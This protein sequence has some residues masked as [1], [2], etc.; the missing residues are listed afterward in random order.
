MNTVAICLYGNS[1]T[2]YDSVVKK[3]ETKFSTFTKSYFCVIDNDP[4]KALW[5]SSFKKAETEILNNTEFDICIAIDLNKPMLLNFI[6]IPD[7]IDNSVYYVRGWFNN[8]RHFSGVDFGSFF[9]KSQTFNRA[10][11]FYLYKSA[12][13]Y[14]DDGFTRGRVLPDEEE[15]FYHLKVFYLPTKCINYENSNLFKRTT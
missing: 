10:C 15:F 2:N 1:D 8:S 14:D 7:E 5:M 4:L 9:S 13:S 6:R 3:C 11:E 12:S